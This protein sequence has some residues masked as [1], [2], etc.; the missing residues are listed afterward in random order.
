MP[1]FCASTPK[2]LL[3]TSPRGNSL[4][5]GGVEIAAH[6]SQKKTLKGRRPR[7]FRE[8]KLQIPPRKVV[9]KGSC[10]EFLKQKGRFLAKELESSHPGL[11]R[12]GSKKI[13]H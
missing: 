7:G 3:N 5:T 9:N 10:S 1:F 12:V 8:R 4:F 2:D 13:T 11:K 6:F